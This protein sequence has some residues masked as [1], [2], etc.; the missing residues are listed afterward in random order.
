MTGRQ[1]RP[2]ILLIGNY[3]P[4]FGGVPKHIEDLV[5][6]LAQEGWDVHVLSGGTT[7]V[8]RGEYLTVYKD[9]RSR[10]VRRGST[11]RFLVREVAAGRAGPAIWASRVLPPRV[12]AAV[13]TRVSL[14]AGIIARHDVR[15]I[16]AYNLLSGVPVGAIAA[17]M[18]DVPLVVTNLGEI[19]SHRREV[20]RQLPLIRRMVT[21]AAA[22]LAPTEH[23]ARS[24]GEL[25]LQPA[26]RV[27]HH[28]IDLRR[29]RPAT[30]MKSLRHRL[31]LGEKDEVVLY[32]GRLVREM[33]LP[34]LLAALPR[35]LSSRPA[36]RLV[37]AGA[38]GDLL[39][40]ALRAA[41]QWP[42]RVTVATDVSSS[43]LPGYYAA[44]TLLVVP[45]LGARA[46]GSLAAAEAMASERPV[47]ASRVG[48]I[49]EFVSDGETGI[50]V[51][52]ADP[53][54]LADAVLMLLADPERRAAMGAA[55]RERMERLFDTDA[56]NHAFER[57]FRS[58][59][60]Q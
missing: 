13:M 36:T 19:Y 33:G 25:D 12:W 56:T 43:N 1:K 42:H 26:V 32:V 14:A 31:G 2:G 55:G 20:E 28:G 7:G 16:S 8:H 54:A 50:L 46:C 37:V 17:Q 57:V 4:P 6:H 21:D 35:L 39:S 5:P 22:L 10:L 59:A 23:C 45:T 11:V 53:D 51:P 18:Y 30:D 41:A 52:P 24:Y 40:E 3:P 58:V 27:I 47:V 9:S 60:R 49:P 48:G 29:F 15:V 34:I 38:A 44:A